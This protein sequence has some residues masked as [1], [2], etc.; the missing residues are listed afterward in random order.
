MLLTKLLKPVFFLLNESL[1]PPPPPPPPPPLPPPVL[2]CALLGLA[3]ELDPSSD[4]RLSGI[5]VAIPAP[6]VVAAGEGPNPAELLRLGETSG[7]DL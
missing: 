4:C 1:L 5:E 7:L 2:L 3:G 6:G